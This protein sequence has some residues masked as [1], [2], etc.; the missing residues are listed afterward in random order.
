MIMVA[1]SAISTTIKG[2]ATPVGRLFSKRRRTPKESLEPRAKT[3]ALCSW[4][5]MLLTGSEA[6]HKESAGGKLTALSF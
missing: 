4:K 2:R 3:A 5:I 1:V 6:T